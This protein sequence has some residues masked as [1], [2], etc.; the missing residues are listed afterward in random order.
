MRYI[1]IDM[2]HYVAVS[3]GE[4]VSRIHT[5]TMRIT[6]DD[7]QVPC[8]A[9]RRHEVRQLRRHNEPGSNAAE[10]HHYQY[11]TWTDIMNF[12]WEAVEVFPAS[13]AREDAPR[14]SYVL[15]SK[16]ATVLLDSFTDRRLF[17]HLNW[18]LSALGLT[19]NFTLECP[20]TDQHIK[21]ST[22]MDKSTGWATRNGRVLEG[23]I[24]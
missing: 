2:M 14:A 15:N 11:V 19:P 23:N 5:Q 24:R 20:G 8:S 6:F 13:N 10:V 17:E 7:M 22:L 16:S 21:G 12:E 1:A 3:Y 9:S 18:E 4:R